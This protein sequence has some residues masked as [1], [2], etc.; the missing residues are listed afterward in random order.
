MVGFLYQ[1][2]EQLLMKLHKQ[3][4][5]DFLVSSRWWVLELT[6]AGND[7]G[8]GGGGAGGYRTSTQTAT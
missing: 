6:H 7:E 1:M 5:I 8:G 4:D 3:Y 2:M